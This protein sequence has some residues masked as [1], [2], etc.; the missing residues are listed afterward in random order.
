MPRIRLHVPSLRV[1]V[2]AATL[3]LL[4]TA[5]THAEE[6]AGKALIERLKTLQRAGDDGELATAIDEVAAVYKSEGAA[7]VQ[8]KLRGAL[9]KI[10]K[11]KKLGSA[12]AAAVRALTELDDPKN[13]WKELS[14]LVPDAKVAEASDL[15]L[16][17]V[18]AAGR[19]A[20]PKAAKPL[21][22]LV[23]K[24][25]DPKLAAASARALGG[26]GA[27]LKGRVKILEDLVSLGK[28]LRPGQSTDKA[29]GSAATER[30]AAVGP[31]IAEGLNELTGR[32]L[33]DFESWEALVD[34]NKRNL[35][36]LFPEP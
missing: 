14:K 26:F 28:R 19:L 34:E 25:K 36:S 33:K 22:E 3:L 17:V 35:K 15:D 13:A 21:L 10:A 9:G 8:A 1:A 20:Q 2:V 16:E 5:A 31:A 6:D 29:A 7:P 32:S 11:D 27:D 23:K 4:S 12:R 18:R 30:W 24:G